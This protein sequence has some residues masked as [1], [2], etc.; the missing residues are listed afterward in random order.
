MKNP[1]AFKAVVVMLLATIAVSTKAQNIAEN[2]LKTNVSAIEKSIEKLQNLKPVYYSFNTEKFAQLKLAK[3]PQYGFKLQSIKDTFPDLLKTSTASYSAGK[4][5]IKT[6]TYQ[7]VRT[8]KL[9]PV[10]VAAIQEQQNAI[11]AL[12]QEIEM[13]KS[14]K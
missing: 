4:N 10:L 12:K 3:S 5:H 6:A 2:D 14:K 13:L 8:E 7:D 11:E 9:I 1:I